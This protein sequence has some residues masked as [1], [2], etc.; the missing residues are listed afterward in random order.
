MLG[1]SSFVPSGSNV[2]FLT[3]GISNPSHRPDV[4]MFSFPSSAI[5]ASSAPSNGTS[6]SLWAFPFPSPSDLIPIHVLSS[7]PL[8]IHSAPSLCSYSFFLLL[9][10]HMRT[11]SC[12]PSSLHHYPCSGFSK[13]PP[14]LRARSRLPV[15]N[16]LRR[17]EGQNADG[18]RVNFP[19]CVCVFVKF[20]VDELRMLSPDVFVSIAQ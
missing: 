9:Q 4:R 13:L 17:S 7:S 15:V 8:I 12:S 19:C 14:R 6:I 11:H 2:P 1:E 20:V 18:L 5:Y 16:S 3:C 10:D